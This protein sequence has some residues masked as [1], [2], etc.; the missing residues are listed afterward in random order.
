M[1]LNSNQSISAFGR[2]YRHI[3]DCVYALI[4]SCRS[5][6]HTPI[7]VRF[8]VIILLV[9][10]SHALTCNLRGALPNS[11]NNLRSSKS[12]RCRFMR[13]IAIRLPSINNEVIYRRSLW[14]L[15]WR[16]CEIG[17]SFWSGRL[18]VDFR[19]LKPPPRERKRESAKD[20]C[21]LA[22]SLIDFYVRRAINSKIYWR[23]FRL[24]VAKL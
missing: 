7:Y 5:H 13:I 3:R 23:R 21:V 1:P 14:L 22:A 17:C 12:A 10:A 20:A 19:R 11:T 8:N 9:A 2:V 18:P 24:A 4:M 16:Q 6:T 15:R